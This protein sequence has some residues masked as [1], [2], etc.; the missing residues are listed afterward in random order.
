MKGDVAKVLV[1]LHSRSWRAR[2]GVE[3]EA[4][5]LDLPARPDV[6]AD[7]VGNALAS[8]CPKYFGIVVPAISL[9]A[10]LTFFCIPLHRA[11]VVRANDAAVSVFKRPDETSNSVR[12]SLYCYPAGARS[13]VRV[14]CA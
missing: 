10:L 4:L 13:S 5:L 6:I 9:V 12:I 14:H 1:R 11:G 2:Y 8:R 3:C 7:C